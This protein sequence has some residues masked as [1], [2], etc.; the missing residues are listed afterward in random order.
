MNIPHRF[1]GIALALCMSL[2]ASAQRFFNLT[3]DE[4][5]VDSMLPQFA[6]SV[7]LD[8]AF[9]DSAYTASIL[10]PEFIDMTPTDVANYRRLSGDTLPALPEIAQRLVY[11]RKRG[12]LEVQFCPLV[13]REGRYRILVSFMLRIDA[14]ARGARAK[15]MGAATR[16]TTAAARYA[17]HSV[18]ALGRW[19]KIRVPA[20]G[21]YQLTTDVVRKAGFADLG[22]VRIYG[23][24]GN[25]QNETLVGTELQALDDLKEIPTCTVG[26]KRLFYARGPVSWGSA[27]ATRRTRNPYSDYGYYFIT[28]AEG[29]PAAIDSSAFLASFYPSADD[30][31]S[32]YEVDGYSWYHGGRNLFDT[33]PIAAGRTKAVTLA[34]RSSSTGGTLSVNVSAGTASEVEVLLGGT[35]LGTLRISLGSYDKGNEA[36]ATYRVSDLHATDTVQIRCVSG[37]PV[38]LDYVSMAWEKAAPA[39]NLMAGTFAT[40]EYV[41]NITNQDL[42]AHGPADMVIVI[43][44]SQKLMEQA[45]RLADFHRDH[46]GLRVRIVPADELYNEF[47]SGTPDAN[48]YRRYLKML[49]DRAGSEAD[50]P[51]HLL[52]FG[53]CVWDNRMR[54][55]ECRNLNPDDYLLCFESENSFNEIYCY[56][57]DGFFAL[58]DDGE[59]GDPQRSD[60]LDMA[61][62]RFPVTTADAAKVMVDKTIGYARN[63]NAG[64]WQNTLMFMGDDGNANLHMNDVNDAAED[65]AARYPGFLVKKVMWDA[66]AGVATSTGNTYPEAT[67]AIKQQQAAG[68]LIMDYAGHGRADQIS[69]EAVLRLADFAGFT[70]K[71]LPLWIT[72]SCDIMAFDGVEETIGETAVLNPG[73]GAVAF[74]GTTRTVYANYN[75]LINMAY[76][77]YVL[78]LTDGRPTTIGEAQRL[79]KNQMIT[80]GADRTTNKLQYSL[81]GDPALALH[82]PTMRVVVDSIN[83]VA[84]ASGSGT[85]YLRAGDVARVVGHVENG[86]DFDG[87]LTAVVRDARQLVTGRLNAS[88]EADTPFRFYERTNT[89]YNGADSIRKGRF[90]FSFAVPMDINYA[91]DNGLMNLHA[92]SADHTRLAHGASS[93]YIVGGSGQ[94]GTDSIGPKVYCYLNTTDF[95][96]GGKVNTTPYFVAQLSDPA[97]INV[98]GSGIG[99]DLQLTIDGDPA[100][101]YTLNDHFQ[102]DFGTYTSGTVAFSIPVLEPGRHTLTFR[103]WD[104]RNNATVSTLDF[105]VVKGLTPSIYSVDVSTNPASTATTFIVSHNMGGSNMDVTIDVFDTAG[106]LLWTHAESGVSTAGAYTVDWNLTQDNGGRLQTGVYLYRVRVASDGSTEASKAKKLIV[107]GN[108]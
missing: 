36:S 43:P 71:N 85:A 88:A 55:A 83:G 3:S 20:S 78:Q 46:D 61:V 41:Y 56:V 87:V 77:R 8:G 108:K 6:Y 37:G 47:S 24:G 34:N 31:H 73:G 35:S 1:L 44:T 95:A 62:G 25:L 90:D 22:K 96:N 65:I 15:R 2:T 70:N 93:S 84:V 58:L 89:L 97:G 99:H 74:F 12:A 29:T 45:Q 51:R 38:R 21:V 68:A 81:L 75:K 63:A 33:E 64:A 104:V 49:Y 76:L 107:V 57:D 79:A 50:M 52:L 23:Y 7:P 26:G 32:L 9:A 69:H 5:R 11:D 67:A 94:T 105:V 91:D 92:V 86:A 42:H 106:R 30:Y 19:A 98:S 60:K 102:Y 14:E 72:A 100:K 17:D 53:D 101:T 28:E 40:P 10:Y 16:A 103:A 18:L 4:V 66:Y 80:S 27:T 82:V 48:A 54:T 39:P 59:G 13:Y